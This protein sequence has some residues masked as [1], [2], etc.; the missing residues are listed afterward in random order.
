MEEM[1]YWPT[2]N[3][4]IR[5]PFRLPRGRLTNWLGGRMMLLVS[6]QEVADLLDIP[7]GSHILEV[8]YGPGSLLRSLRK[9]PARRIC[10]V[11]PSAQMRRMAQRRCPRA[12]L[13]LGTAARTG[14]AD[15]EFDRVVS[16]N[17]VA[18]WP[19]LS[20][21]LRELHRVTRPGGLVLIA[22]HGGRN[23]SR[24]AQRMALS[25]RVWSRIEQELGELFTGTTRHELDF[26][27]AFTATRP[28]G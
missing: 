17:G 21:G 25:Q 2:D 18:G 24:L 16:V 26:L 10:G 28:P 5:L 4:P 6:L 8:G 14:F 12:D 15:G 1:P 11:D 13:R 7:P 20:A 22:W 27:T 23:D 9:S 19:D 3:E